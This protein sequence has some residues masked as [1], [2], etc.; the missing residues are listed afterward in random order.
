LFDEITGLSVLIPEGKEFSSS[1][2]AAS[3]VC[4]YIPYHAGLPAHPK[5]TTT[6]ET[7][8]KQRTASMGPARHAAAVGALLAA[9]ALLL[10]AAVPGAR[11]Q[12]ETGELFDSLHAVR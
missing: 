9:A 10:S 12:A 6:T 3:L 5:S 1:L 11:A 2:P 8:G 7:S 4:V